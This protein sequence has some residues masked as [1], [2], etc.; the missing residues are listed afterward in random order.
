MLKLCL[1]AAAAMAVS[2][3][4]ATPDAAAK[5]RTMSKDA[6]ETIY[7]HPFEGA[8]LEQ[9]G[10]TIDQAHT[11]N[12]RE[13]YVWLGAAELALAG[14][15]HSGDFFDSRNYEPRVVENALA[16]AER[17]VQ[18]DDKLS[19][20]HVV[21][22]KIFLTLGRLTDAQRALDRAHALD[23]KAFK[24][25]FYQAVWFKKQGDW[26]KFQQ[27]LRTAGAVAKGDWDQR[28]LLY[29]LEAIAELRGDD[30]QHEKIHKAIINL[31]P[32]RPWPHGNYGWFLLERER[33]DDAI[34]E[35]EKA[36]SLNSYPNAIEGLEQARRR[37]DAARGRR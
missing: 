10:K 14:G 17:A 8:I 15:F 23:P 31:D 4:A 9:A 37:R 7:Q 33:Y 11:L 32:R 28:S 18:L 6:Y 25:L 34:A 19:D 20:A 36:V 29:Q 12:D 21:A 1:F 5:A 27:G 3:S 16:L 13:P 2:L 30:E 26:P 22:A 24:P 35:F